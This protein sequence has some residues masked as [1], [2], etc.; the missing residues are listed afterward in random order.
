M[1]DRDYVHE[2]ED[3]MSSFADS[4]RKL[5]AE[6][7]Q[8]TE[9]SEYIL[10]RLRVLSNVDDLFAGADDLNEFTHVENERHL[11]KAMDRMNKFVRAAIDGASI[12][13]LEGL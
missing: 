9:R 1:N 7:N 11:I 6:K 4:V 8:L 13:E 3:D 10:K 5:T 12:E 2:M